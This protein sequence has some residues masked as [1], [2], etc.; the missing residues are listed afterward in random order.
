[1]GKCC[2]KVFLC[3]AEPVENCSKKVLFCDTEPVC[4]TVA[5][6]YWFVIG[7]Q[8]GELLQE[9]IVMSM[10]AIL[11]NRRRMHFICQ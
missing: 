10:R 7:S 9:D 2:R 8:C 5:G 11:E 3:D 4:I 6:R 1:M